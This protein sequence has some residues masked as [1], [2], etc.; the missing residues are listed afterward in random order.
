M[1]MQRGLMSELGFGNLEALE[2]EFDKAL[3]NA[4]GKGIL[5]KEHQQLQAAGLR[6]WVANH[7]KVEKILKP[8]ES[9][10]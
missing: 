2:E 7:F 6:L 1:K 4:K 5:S 3:K 9:E 8:E 10:K